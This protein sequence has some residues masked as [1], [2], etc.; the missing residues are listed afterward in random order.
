MGHSV[1]GF[2]FGFDVDKGRARSSLVTM[3]TPSTTSY[4][5]NCTL[6]TRQHEDS[7]KKSPSG[8]QDISSWGLAESSPGSGHRTGARGRLMQGSPASAEAN[9]PRNRHGRPV[10]Q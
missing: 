3:C 2:G 7:K 5:R 10:A 1:V 9:F 4:Q 6:S 8:S